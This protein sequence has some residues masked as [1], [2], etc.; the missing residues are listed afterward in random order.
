MIY[1]TQV[2]KVAVG[3]K[4]TEGPL[5]HPK[6]FLLKIAGVRPGNSHRKTNEGTMQSQIK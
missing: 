6:G 2:E 4:F 3:F 1:D 5:W